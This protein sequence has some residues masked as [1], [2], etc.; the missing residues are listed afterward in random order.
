LA[1]RKCLLLAL[2]LVFQQQGTAGI[3]PL[4]RFLELAQLTPFVAASSGAPQ[5]LATRLQAL[6]GPYDQQQ[7]QQLAPCRKP[8]DLTRCEEENVHG[9]QPCRVAIEPVADFLVLEV[10][11]PPRDA[12]T[13]N[14]AVGTALLGLPVTVI[15]G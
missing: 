4:G 2:P 7:R 6:L 14:Q 10:Y 1:V 13:G 3:R 9:D 12:D 15:P 5:R 8:K 11:R